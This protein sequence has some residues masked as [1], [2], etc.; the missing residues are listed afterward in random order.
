[1]RALSPR[2][3][4]AAVGF[5]TSVPVPRRSAAEDTD[6]LAGATLFP[7][8]GAVLGALV[9]GTAALLTPALP[10][11]LA[12][13]LAVALELALTGA[14]HADALADSADGLGGR[15]R[16][17]A[18][19]IMRDHSIGAYGAAALMLDLLAKTA[20]L[21]ALAEHDAVLP[22]VAAYAVSR[23][24][25]LPLAAALPYARSGEGVGRLLAQR[26]RKRSAL[27]GV[28]LA[29]MVAVAATGPAEAG[30]TIVC[31]VL[32][33]ATAGALARRRI[34]GVTGDVMGA[35]TELTATLG[36]VVAVGLAA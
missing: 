16:D 14:L 19:A 27:A 4:I 36:L 2:P 1:M 24:A 13:T 15:D 30:A 33:V 3:L 35:A 26:F 11:L 7:L 6:L 31:L 12:A 18:L 32:T 5:L 20:A 17:H 9:G 34:R 8:V 22:V 25:P 29:G 21:A 10:A 23:A 28:A